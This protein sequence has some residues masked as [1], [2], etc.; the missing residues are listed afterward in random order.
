M[1]DLVSFS[2]KYRKGKLTRKTI[3]NYINTSIEEKE[4]TKNNENWYSR[5]TCKIQ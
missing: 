1:K 2:I 5:P 3:V 4:K